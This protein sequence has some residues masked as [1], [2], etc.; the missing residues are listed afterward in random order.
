MDTRARVSQCVALCVCV[1]VRG[2]W[3]REEGT[4]DPRPGMATG[5]RVGARR[6]NIAVSDAHVARSGRL[7]T[8]PRPSWLGLQP[9]ARH[10][11]VPL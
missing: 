7:S 2:I 3:G 9:E 1:C 6:S 10:Y 11:A 5:V 8:Q 4:E